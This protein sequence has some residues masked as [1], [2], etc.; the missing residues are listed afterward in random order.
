MAFTGFD[1]FDR[2]V[3]TANGWLKDLQETLGW[4]ERRHAYA[5]FQAVLHALRDR[6][7]HHETVHLGEQLPMILA[8]AYYSGWRPGAT[9]RRFRDREAFLDRVAEELHVSA[10]G[11]DV[12][13]AT[14]G[15]FDLLARRVTAGELQDV[16]AILPE[17][18]RELWTTPVAAVRASEAAAGARGRG[19]SA[20]GEV[21]VTRDWNVV[22]TVHPD[23]YR[24]AVRLLSELGGVRV[25]RSQY[26]NVL[27]LRAESPSGFLDS[28]S[29]RTAD[30]PALLDEVI[31]H[32]IPV[33][34]RFVF[35]SAEE[36]E[37]GALRLLLDRIEVLAGRSFH[38]RVH[39]HGFEGRISSQDEE[40]FLG[41]A[42]M[43]ELD[44]RGETATVDFDDPDLLVV[45]ETISTRGGIAILDRDDRERYPF[46]GTE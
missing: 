19:E 45:V 3:H 28:L 2:A 8:G 32:V 9:P 29:E 34:E 1:V 21:R 42:I 31:S 17:G 33:E 43:D 12:E 35:H 44:R 10:P 24:R 26:G 5:A 46:L 39:R 11:A 14:H 41:G 18:L 13:H 7:P 6:L 20:L 23:G 4:D 30:D 40:G 25:G 36:F 27:L 38:V 37:A 22:V 16:V 15:V